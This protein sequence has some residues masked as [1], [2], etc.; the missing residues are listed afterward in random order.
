MDT[1]SKA[2]GCRYLLCNLRTLHYSGAVA[3]AVA[4]HDIPKE[5]T[6]GGTKSGSHQMRL[7]VQTQAHEWNL[8][9]HLGFCIWLSKGGLPDTMS[10]RKLS[11]SV[12][13]L[14]RVDL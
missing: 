14:V 5:D 9:M 11:N 7:F 12:G 4:P 1:S 8:R 2:T 3:P 13:I 6:G 10:K